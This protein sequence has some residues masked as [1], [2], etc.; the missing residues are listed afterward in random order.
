MT[1]A[2]PHSTAREGK[3]WKS[4]TEPSTGLIHA[5]PS[6]HQD[7]VTLCYKTDWIGETPG[8]YVELKPTCTDC[9]G[10]IR[11]CQEQPSART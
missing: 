11:A 4:V 3:R 10:M 1:P 5:R 8:E 2:N 6:S 7:A 9:L